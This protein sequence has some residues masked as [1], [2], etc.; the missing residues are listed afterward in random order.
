MKRA[1]LR[2]EEV[3]RIIIVATMTPPSEEGLADWIAAR[4]LGGYRDVGFHYYIDSLGG[5]V[6]GVSDSE[7]GGIVPRYARS[8]VVVLL[9]GGADKR[10]EPFNNFD[11]GQM[12]SL[13]LLVNDIQKKYPKAQPTLYRELFRGVN[14]VFAHED[15]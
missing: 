8:A 14:P 10:G 5:I 11:L 13:R 9:Q 2:P 4:S 15:Y 7:R 12:Q 6:A 1:Q 3:S